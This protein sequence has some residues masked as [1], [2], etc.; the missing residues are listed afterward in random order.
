MASKSA[1]GA[2]SFSV[3]RPALRRTFGGLGRAFGDRR[4]V[5]AGDEGAL[6]GAYRGGS[7]FPR[8]TPP[9]LRLGSGS[10]R[11][12]EGGA[13]LGCAGAGWHTPEAQLLLGELLLGRGDRREAR[14]WLERAQRSNRIALSRRASRL[15]EA[16][17]PLDPEP[18]PQPQLIPQRMMKNKK[19]DPVGWPRLASLRSWGA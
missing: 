18:S 14:V 12:A 6:R 4:R 2:L 11:L 19:I 8:A 16:L 3:G 9:K 13:V 7:R 1:I 10:A 5:S 15:R 17:T